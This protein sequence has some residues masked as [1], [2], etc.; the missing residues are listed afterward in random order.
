MGQLVRGDLTPP[1]FRQIVARIQP[2][3]GNRKILLWASVAARLKRSD[4]GNLNCAKGRPVRR[5]RFQWQSLDCQRCRETTLG[6][7]MV[8]LVLLPS[9]AVGHG[10]EPFRGEASWDGS[11]EPSSATARPDSPTG[12]S[13]RVALNFSRLRPGQVLAVGFNVQGLPGAAADLLLGAMFPDGRTV[14]LFSRLGAV[15]YT[16]P[17]TNLGV[18]PVEAVPP[19][20][21]LNNPGFLQVP[22]PSTIPA[23]NY[24]IFAALL[25][26][27]ALASNQ[28][29]VLAADSK[30][31]TLSADP[32]NGAQP[33]LQS[34]FAGQYRIASPFDHSYPTQ[35]INTNGVVMHYWGEQIATG[36][37]P[38]SDPTKSCRVMSIIRDTTSSF[39]RAPL[40]SRLVM[41]P[42]C[43][44]AHS[45]RLSVQPSTPP[46]TP[47]RSFTST[48]LR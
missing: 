21:S 6:L 31:L 33:I 43:S 10:P 47:G 27:G 16:G 7:V 44:P 18:L 3:I 30:T 25:Q 5:Q 14:V 26:Q 29:V 32:P 38:K 34:P 8:L 41:A 19:G 40:Y 12:P 15:T 2:L 9:R 1:C 35:F 36:A 48:M 24:L 4:V 11:Y 28:L 46:S 23:G 37:F 39:Q 13:A 42:S 22:L 20:F 17:A 45:G